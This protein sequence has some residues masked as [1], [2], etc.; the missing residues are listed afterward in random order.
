MKSYITMHTFHNTCGLATR[1]QKKNKNIIKAKIVKKHQQHHCIQYP[2]SKLHYMLY[3]YIEMLRFALRL[4]ASCTVRQRIRALSSSNTPFKSNRNKWIWISLYGFA[5]RSR[6][7]RTLS[8]C[9]CFC[10]CRHCHFFCFCMRMWMC[11]RTL[12]AV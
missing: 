1:E 11:M 12:V 10:C 2:H 6:S 9:C 5:S 4:I 3:M 7:F 8:F